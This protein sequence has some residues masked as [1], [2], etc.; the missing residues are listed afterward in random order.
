VLFMGMYCACGQRINYE[1]ECL[2]D[3]DGWISCA[4]YP[5]ERKNKDIPLQEKPQKS[6]KYFA[7]YVNSNCDRYECEAYFSLE[8]IRKDIHQACWSEPEN[9]DVHWDPWDSETLGP[10]AWKPIKENFEK[11][12][13]AERK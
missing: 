9:I 11:E 8:P 7:R 5:P 2:C 12:I 10:Y 4:D 1:F 6:G 13:E 3:W